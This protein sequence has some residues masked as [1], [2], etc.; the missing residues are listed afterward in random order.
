LCANVKGQII[1]RFA[2]ELKRYL[3]EAAADEVEGE[4]CGPLADALAIAA[5]GAVDSVGALRVRD[6]DVDEADGFG[7]GGAGGA[8]DAG[9]AEADG[10]AGARA[11][12]FWRGLWRLQRRQR[13][14]S[15]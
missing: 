15:R 1:R 6:G 2:R 7:F 14:A 8:G 13:R 5:E 9:D 12:A 3:H 4:L 10:C 11:D